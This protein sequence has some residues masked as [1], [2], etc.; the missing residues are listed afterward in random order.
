MRRQ[1]QSAMQ[2]ACFVFPD[3]EKLPGAAAGMRA[4]Y[5]DL[6]GGHYEITRDY[7]ELRSLACVAMLIM[8]DL[9]GM[10]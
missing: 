7:A 9:L 3:R 5:E 4:L 6:A 8:E 10:T 1:I 2:E